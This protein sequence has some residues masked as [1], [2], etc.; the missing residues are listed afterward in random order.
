MPV[1]AWTLTAILLTTTIAGAAVG[2]ETPSPPPA[3][4]S[5]PAKVI[6]IAPGDVDGFWKRLNAPDFLWMTGQEF[7]K[8]IEA[9]T[10]P[11]APPQGPSV[12]E[13]AI[14]G[15]VEGDLAR[16][17][18]YL[19]VVVGEGDAPA[20]V[21]IRLDGLAVTL[22]NEAGRDLPLRQGT[23]PTAGWQVEVRGPGRHEVRVEL[24]APVQTVAPGKVLTLAIPEAPATRLALDVP[25]GATDALADGKLPVAI[26]P[27]PGDHARLSAHLPPRPAL[28]LTWHARADPAADLPPLLAARGEIALDVDRGAIHVNSSWSVR[29]ERGS[30]ADLELRLDPGEE[31]LELA[32]DG[33]PLP[34]EG[35]RDPASGT[36]RVPL[37]EPLKPEAPARRLTLST[38]KPLPNGDPSRWTYAGLPIAHASAQSGVLA[39]AQGEGLWLGGEPGRDLIQI[40]PRAELPDS[41][42]RPSTVLAYHFLGQPFELALRADP[43]PPRARASA[44]TTVAVDL[45]GAA[46][47]A[48]VD[49]RTT[50]GRVFEVRL[51]APTTLDLRDVGARRRR[52]VSPPPG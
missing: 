37:P 31:L 27:A 43:A 23:P 41:L 13:L 12:V 45:E 44:R 39:V 10:S 11:A 24:L 2:A 47:D 50:R 52:G 36:V 33:R 19:I 8:R 38:R 14:G 32:L 28:E 29:A 48:W 7:R 35:R 3:D 5:G 25:A 15:A 26:E 34:T 42:R 20:W 49:Y 21:P 6:V 22:A 1:R 16:L 51:T 9:A 4:D 40:D 30:V 17:N 46:V 18:L